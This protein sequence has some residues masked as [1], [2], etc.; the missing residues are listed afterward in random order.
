[1]AYQTGNKRKLYLTTAKSLSSTK[2]T[3]LAGEQTNSFNLTAEMLEVSDKTSE[4]AQF[5]AGKKGA[6][7]NV[8]VFA[9]ADDATGQ[10]ML[11]TA[12]YKGTTVFCFIGSL[13]TDGAPAEGE[14]FEALVSSVSETN[15]NAGVASRDIALQVTGEVVSVPAL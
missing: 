4:W 15:D 3:A 7:A 1:M 9:D 6:T 12:L 8:T 10:T 13:G 2:F 11:R 5:I 14:L